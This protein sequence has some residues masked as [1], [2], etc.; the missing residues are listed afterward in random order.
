[1]KNVVLGLMFITAFIVI[2]AL[3]I[4]AMIPEDEIPQTVSIDEYEEV[5][6]K[7]YDAA[8]NL[9]L[10]IKKADN[11][12]WYCV[13]SE[14]RRIVETYRVPSLRILLETIQQVEDIPY[15]DMADAYD[16]TLQEYDKAYWEYMKITRI[17]RPE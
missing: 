9:I 13:D 12:D 14:H 15:N 2:S 16:W 4:R 5:R 17:A 3:G 11:G 1:M 10:E 6:A 8:L 7:L